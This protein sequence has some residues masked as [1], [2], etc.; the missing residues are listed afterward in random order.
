MVPEKK[1]AYTWQYENYA[2]ESLVSFKLFPEGD[3]TR[4]RLTHEGLDTFPKLPD[5]A[6]KNFTMG[7]T[8]IVGTG[9]KDFVER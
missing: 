7:W 9:L 1:L 4:V 8:H 3:R 6:R 5:F 2:G